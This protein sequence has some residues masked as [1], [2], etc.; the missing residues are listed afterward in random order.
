MIK[1]D[2]LVG[3]GLL[4]GGLGAALTNQMA[5]A[6]SAASIGAVGAVNPQAAGQQ[7]GAAERTLMIGA[8]LVQDER[9]K[10]DAAG[11]VDVMFA[12]QSALTVG[13]NSEVVLD[14]F[15]YDPGSQTGELAI[16]ITQ[17]A[18]RFIGGK[19]SKTNAVQ[20]QGPS[21]TMSIRGGI[22]LFYF[23]PGKDGYA[24]FVY[25]RELKVTG[26][27]G[28]E[29]IIERPG[30]AILFPADGG[31]PSEPFRLTA[32]QLEEIRQAL[33]SKNNGQAGDLP[34]GSLRSVTQIGSGDLPD[35][36]INDLPLG[37]LGFDDQ[38]VLDSLNRFVVV[39]SLQ[40][41]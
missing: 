21:A 13:A 9:I 24:V 11:L 22:G 41:S 31:P 16:N 20:I 30:F 38:E 34:A 6:Q 39:D 33:E 37:E 27:D 10:T 29:R 40:A 32:Q 26:N 25:G 14:K 3:I 7:P 1:R 18:M 36:G 35:R 2:W 8:S 28:I 19:I 15:V 23:P 17:G 12:D 4:S 5:L